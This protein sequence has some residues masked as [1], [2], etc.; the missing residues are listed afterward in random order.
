MKQISLMTILGIFVGGIALTAL[1]D[2]VIAQES[3]SQRV[4]PAQGEWVPKGTS[5]AAAHPELWYRTSQRPQAGPRLIGATETPAVIEDNRGRRDTPASSPRAASRVPKGAPRARS[6]NRASRIPTEATQ[7]PS[8]R[9]VAAVDEPEPE[10]I[11]TPPGQIPGETEADDGYDLEGVRIYEAGEYE[12]LGLLDTVGGIEG[13]ADCGGGECG[14]C[15]CGGACG[16]YDCATCGHAGYCGGCQPLGGLL[17]TLPSAWWA[18]D[19]S[20]FLGVHGFKGPTDLGNFGIHEGV[21]FGAPVGVA[22]ALGYQFGFTAVHSN[23]SGYQTAGGAAELDDERDQIFLTAGLFRRAPCGGWQWGVAFD[24]MHDSYYGVADLKQIRTE[25]GFVSADG[26]REIGYF[27]AYGSGGDDLILLDRDNIGLEPTDMFAFFYRRNFCN[28]GDGRLWAGFSGA[29]DGLLGADLRAPLGK[30][31]AIE[32]RINYLIPSEGHGDGGYQQESWAL[33]IRLV[34]Y[35]GQ[36]AQSALRSPYR[37]MF[38]VA[39]NSTFMTDAN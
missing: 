22:P 6:Q 23:F 31:W 20:I 5:T 39:D 33:S 25:T 13:C 4:L 35:L 2:D 15:D 3:T 17:G 8:M 16:P 18:R 38:D 1:A 14:G 37:P 32:N 9:T 27:G 29:G 36:P 7:P 10:D 19:F 30:S 34:W 24:L 21:N 26:R 28:G 11:R 12:D